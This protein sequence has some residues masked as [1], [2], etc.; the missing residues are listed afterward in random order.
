LAI[1]EKHDMSVGPG[2]IANLLHQLIAALDTG[3]YDDISVA[4]VEARL[5]TGDLFPYLIQVLDA[6]VD[7]S[8]FNPGK[9][10]LSELARAKVEARVAALNERLLGLVDAFAGRE[11]WGIERSGLCLLLTYGVFM[12]KLQASKARVSTWSKDA[13]LPDS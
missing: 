4:E 8:L 13:V 6:D 1:Q 9:S 7:L 11:Q 12:L 3:K 5:R 10:E 2:I